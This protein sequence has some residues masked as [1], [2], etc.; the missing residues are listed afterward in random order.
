MNNKN[1][2]NIDFIDLVVIFSKNKLTIFYFLIIS[3]FAFLIYFYLLHSNNY[4]SK[5]NI[6]TNNELLLT[7]NLFFNYNNKDILLDNYKSE[8]YSQNNF[9]SWIQNFKN[10]SFSK[11]EFLGINTN[12]DILFRND[13]SSRV[14]NFLK[15]DYN[16]YLIINSNNTKKINHIYDYANYINGKITNKFITLLSADLFEY[17]SINFNNDLKINIIRE[18]N[19]LKYIIDNL[20]LNNIYNISNPTYPINDSIKF[21]KILLF[22]LFIGLSSSFLFIILKYFYYL[23]TGKQN[24]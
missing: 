12:L 20:K 2:I 17:N 3:V 5:I 4:E 21:E 10:S 13:K 6:D 23:K 7:N 16:Y 11:N 15:D 24:Y 14:F 19:S 22:F 9:S 8:F 1:E 18:R